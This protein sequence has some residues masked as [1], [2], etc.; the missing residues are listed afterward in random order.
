MRRVLLVAILLFVACAEQS[1]PDNVRWPSGQ[2]VH[3]R[4]VPP[5]KPPSDIAKLTCV[6][7][8]SAQAHGF[9]ENWV[10]DP[11]FLQIEEWSWWTYDSAGNMPPTVSD[12]IDGFADHA[13]RHDYYYDCGHGWHLYQGAKYLISMQ[14]FVTDYLCG[15]DG[16]AYFDPALLVGPGPMIAQSDMTQDDPT[17]GVGFLVDPGD[18]DGQANPVPCVQ[19]PTEPWRCWSQG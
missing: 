16:Y 8:L 18:P 2:P 15:I 4:I 3:P 7:G 5:E 14:T 10:Q 12:C 19:W 1:Y 9:V 6:D 17:N 13:I 11:E